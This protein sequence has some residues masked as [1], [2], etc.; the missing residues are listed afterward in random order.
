MRAD[1]MTPVT[2]EKWPTCTRSRI[3]SNEQ[4]HLGG[5]KMQEN[6]KKNKKEEKV[7][8]KWADSEVVS[9]GN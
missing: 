2:R 7:L 1:C 4:K 9:D 5:W 8:S 6:R 3:S